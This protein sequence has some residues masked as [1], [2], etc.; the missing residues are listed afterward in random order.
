MPWKN[1]CIGRKVK[2]SCPL[3]QLLASVDVS[4]DPRQMEHVFYPA[5]LH[6][7]LLLDR[8]AKSHWPQQWGKS[9]SHQFPQRRLGTGANVQAAESKMPRDVTSL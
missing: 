9:Q 8:C 7:F 2:D 1:T 6:Q 3:Q 4:S 5:P